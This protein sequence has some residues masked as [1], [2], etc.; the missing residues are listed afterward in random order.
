M[1]N[2]KYH[3]RWWQFTKERFEP[4]SH[5][6]MIIVFLLVHLLMA[7]EIFHVKLNIFQQLLLFMATL[8]FYFK[9]RLYDEVKDYS[10][11]VIINKHRPLPR[12][13]LQHQ[14]MFLGMI[15]CIVIELGLFS[16][17]GLESLM[18]IM[19]TIAYSLL[20]YKE[21]FIKNLIRPH[22]TT[23]AIMH[24]VVTSF[25]SLAIFSYFSDFSFYKILM[26]PDCLKFAIANWSLFN[27]FEFGRKTFAPSEER[28]NVDSYSSLFGKSGAVALVMSQVIIAH[29]M[30][31]NISFLH[32]AFLHW[33]HGFLF[34]FLILITL[35]YLNCDKIE[36]AKRFRLISSV[37]IIIFYLTTAGSFLFIS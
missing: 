32:N 37:Y 29:V 9:L 16:I 4:L 33:T 8:A 17:Q 1:K 18:S 36:N 25:L 23:Y 19:I 31:L 3:Y 11:D 12:G 35:Q 10:L 21:F 20:M 7:Q 30:I 5:I 15:I 34:L 26:T 2:L 6:T 14:D 28:T 24:T 22:L 27:I 13:L